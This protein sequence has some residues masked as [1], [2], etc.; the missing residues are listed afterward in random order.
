[1]RNGLFDSM[2]S[3]II[4]Y[5]YNFIKDQVQGFCRIS[6]KILEGFA[7]CSGSPK[8]LADFATVKNERG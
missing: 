4:M 3:L 8:Y 7:S 5:N 1:M 6:S 2:V